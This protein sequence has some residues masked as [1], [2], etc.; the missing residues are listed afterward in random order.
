MNEKKSSC[1]NMFYSNSTVKDELH[2]I[3]KWPLYVEFRHMIHKAIR[4]NECFNS[5]QV[6]CSDR[7][8]F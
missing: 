6:Q 8:I 4:F 1:K 3:L 7:A 5:Y 2:V